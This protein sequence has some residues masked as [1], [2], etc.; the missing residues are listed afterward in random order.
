MESGAY[1]L[2]IRFRGRFFPL[3][4]NADRRHTC[5]RDHAPSHERSLEGSNMNASSLCFRAAMVLLLCGMAWGLQ[6]AISQD[7]SAFP[8]HA[9]LNLLGFAPLF[10]FGVYYRLSPD[11]EASRLPLPQVWIWI[12]G[13]ILMAL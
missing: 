9:H 4:S 13:T 2:V 12:A 5:R 8:A 7:H 10:L 3:S 6:M 1:S 11:V